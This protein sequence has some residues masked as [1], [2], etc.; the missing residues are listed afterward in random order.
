MDK[1]RRA[2]LSQVLKDQQAL[3]W[4]AHEL[5]KRDAAGTRVASK[6]ATALLQHL[7][8]V[9]SDLS[10]ATMEDLRDALDQQLQQIDL[11]MEELTGRM[12]CSLP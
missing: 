4:R 12:A 6:E 7:R 2:S 5:W 11:R 3:A 10:P 9:D 8:Q 1:R